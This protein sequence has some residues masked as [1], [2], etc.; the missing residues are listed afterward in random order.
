MVVTE[1]AGVEVVRASPPV[2][3]ASLRSVIVERTVAATLHGPLR[4]LCRASGGLYY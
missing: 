2:G 3:G 4:L 1:V